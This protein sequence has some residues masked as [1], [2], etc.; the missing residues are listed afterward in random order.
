MS[1]EVTN[2]II[3]GQHPEDTL[4]TRQVWELIVKAAKRERKENE[5]KIHLTWCTQDVIERAKERQLDLTRDEAREI[6]IDI[7]DKH[8]CTIGVCWDT[9]DIFTNEFLETQAENAH[10]ARFQD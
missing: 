2:L 5:D 3:L 6:L 9:L 7:E 8:D 1:T 4:P 10:R